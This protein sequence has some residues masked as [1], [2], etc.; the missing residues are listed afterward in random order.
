M[1]KTTDVALCD[2]PVQAN[3]PLH[4][5]RRE[6]GT[7]TGTVNPCGGYADPPRYTGFTRG[8]L[9]PGTDSA[10]R[11]NAPKSLII[12]SLT[13]SSGIGLRDGS[14]HSVG[15]GQPLP[16]FRDGWKKDF[17]SGT[18][19]S[20]LKK[21][22]GCQGKGLMVSGRPYSL[23]TI[24]HSYRWLTLLLGVTNEKGDPAVSTEDGTYPA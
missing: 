9:F 5:G 12:F 22:G 20:L 6:G 7:R 24:L 4:T 16:G 18:F 23:G 11:E 13:A 2:L 1:S 21:P 17:F 10:S 19:Q 14:V 8:L 15:E 3:R